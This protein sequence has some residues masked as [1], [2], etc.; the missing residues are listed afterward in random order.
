VGNTY[1]STTGAATLDAPFVSTSLQL[2]D[3]SR[4]NVSIEVDVLNH[5][6]APVTGTLRGLFG[7]VEFEPRVSLDGRGDGRADGSAESPARKRIKFDSSTHPSLR[8]QNPKV[9]WPVGYGD[10]NLYDVQLKLELEG[11]TISDTKSLKVGIRQMAYTED[12]GVLKIWINGR[13]FVARG[14]NWGFSES[15]L[16][17]R[18]REYDAALR[19]ND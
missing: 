2:P 9:W 14:G 19:G 1:L 7:E 4:A 13:R 3:I 8:L 6:S 15:M 17:Y 10:P 16:R 12:G 5:Q 18:A 11:G